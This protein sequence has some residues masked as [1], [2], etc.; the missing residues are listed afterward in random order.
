[1]CIRDRIKKIADLANDKKIE[2]ISNAND[3]SDREGMR[4]VIYIKREA[5]A[6]VVLNKLYK[7]TLLQTSFSV[8]NVALVLSLIHI[9]FFIMKFLL[10]ISLLLGVSSININFLKIELRQIHPGRCSR[11]G[12]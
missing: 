7:M 1:M 3:E 11:R 5:N 4:I 6:S 2:G 8:N 12:R 9:F 10:N